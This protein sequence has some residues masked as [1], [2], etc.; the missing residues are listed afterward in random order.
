MPAVKYDR[1]YGRCRR[2]ALLVPCARCAWRQGC[3]QL[4][5]KPFKAYVAREGA[6]IEP[7]EARPG[8]A[9]NG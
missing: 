4:L 2:D 8:V 7:P 6:V 1:D 5:C 3:R 9:I